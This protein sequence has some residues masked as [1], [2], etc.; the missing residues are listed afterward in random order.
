MSAH[1]ANGA[2][3]LALVFEYGILAECVGTALAYG[4][5]RLAFEFDYLRLEYE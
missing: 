2:H 5:A 1:C 3:H 4:L